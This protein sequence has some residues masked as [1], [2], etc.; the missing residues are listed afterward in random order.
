MK[1]EQGAMITHLLKQRDAA[2]DELTQLA[3]KSAPVDV[4]EE[5]AV[6][7]HLKQEQQNVNE[8]I[9]NTV[10]ASLAMPAKKVSAPR[11]PASVNELYSMIA[12]AEQNAAGKS[13]V[14][15][16]RIDPNTGE[17]IVG[18]Y[19]AYREDAMSP[20]TQNRNAAIV[21]NNPNDIYIGGR[22]P[23]GSRVNAT[24]TGEDDTFYLQKKFEPVKP[25]P[26]T[27]PNGRTMEVDTANMDKAAWLYYSMMEPENPIDF[28]GYYK[29]PT[30]PKHE[31]FV[32][33]FARGATN[34]I[35]NILLSTAGF[36]AQSEYDLG[37]LF[38]NL[39][40]AKETAAYH[41][42]A[43]KLARKT[44]DELISKY[45]WQYGP[46]G[47][48]DAYGNKAGYIFGQAGPM[49]GLSFVSMPTSLSVMSVAEA[50]D[51]ARQ[52]RNAFMDKGVSTGWALGA[53]AG[54]GAG[55]FALG[56]IPEWLGGMYMGAQKAAK[57][58]V[59]MS[60]EAPQE[61]RQ[62][63][64]NRNYIT[65]LSE[66][67]LSEPEQDIFTSVVAGE[68]VDWEAALY[69]MLSAF[70]VSNATLAVS[71]P[72]PAK[73]IQQN[74]AKFKQFLNDHEEFLGMVVKGSG[75][76]IT[77]ANLDEALDLLGD[78]E[79]AGDLWNYL[80]E[81]IVANFDKLTDEQ[82]K[83]LLEKVKQLDP[84][85]NLST[86]FQKLDERIDQMLDDSANIDVAEGRTTLTEDQRTLVKLLLRGVAAQQLA[87]YNVLPSQMT[88][89]QNV[90]G[91]YSDA[92]VSSVAEGSTNVE[93]GQITVN[94]AIQESAT[95]VGTVTA[96]PVEGSLN[97]QA[98]ANIKNEFAS[99]G[100]SSAQ[101]GGFAGL[102]HEF[103]HW[104]E[105][106]TGLPNVGEFMAGIQQLAE[107][108]VP[109]ITAGKEGA[110]LSEAYAY[111]IGYAGDKVKSAL[112]LS[113]PAA[114]Y[115]DFMNLA[116]NAED[117]AQG[118]AAAL[119]GYMESYRNVLKT[120]KQLVDDVIDAYGAPQLRGAIDNFIKTG[121]PGA[122]KLEDMRALNAAL[123]SA[124]DTETASNLG[125]IFE[126]DERANS[127]MRRY[128]EE[129][130]KLL[131]KDRE[132]AA[133]KAEEYRR[134]AN[135]MVGVGKEITPST[136]REDTFEQKANEIV[137]EEETEAQKIDKAIY[138][139]DM[140]GYEISYTDSSAYKSN[141]AKKRELMKQKRKIEGYTD[142]QID[143]ADKLQEQIDEKEAAYRE[144]IMSVG[145]E[146]NY[147]V[148]TET[149]KKNQK[150]REKNQDALRKQHEEERVTLQKEL[151]NILSRA[152]SR[153]HTEDS[154]AEA[155]ANEET[156]PE[157]KPA[158]EGKK[159]EIKS[160][161]HTEGPRAGTPY[162]VDELVKGNYDEEP[163]VVVGYLENAAQ[164]AKNENIGKETLAGKTV[165]LSSING[166][167]QV[168]LEPSLGN[169][170]ADHRAAYVILAKNK[171]KQMN[172]KGLLTE[173]HKR[174][175]KNTEMFAVRSKLKDQST[176]VLNFLATKVATKV[177]TPD[178]IS[179]YTAM[180]EFDKA[181]SDL[182]VDFGP[183]TPVETAIAAKTAAE[184]FAYQLQDLS[185]SKDSSVRRIIRGGPSLGGEEYLRGMLPEQVDERLSFGVFPSYEGGYFH[186]EM[187]EPNRSM[188]DAVADYIYSLDKFIEDKTFEEEKQVFGKDDKQ[189]SQNERKAI[190]TL[191]EGVVYQD[192]KQLLFPFARNE[193]RVTASQKRAARAYLGT[194][195]SADPMNKFFGVAYDTP[196][197]S[198]KFIDTSV[199]STARRVISRPGATDAEIAGAQNILNAGAVM[200]SYT[201]PI[202]G[203][204]KRDIINTPTPLEELGISMEEA[205]EQIRAAG[206]EPYDFLNG[207]LADEAREKLSPDYIRKN[208]ND[209]DPDVY[210]KTRRSMLARLLKDIP[211]IGESKNRAERLRILH[212][213]SSAKAAVDQLFQDV[214]DSE[215]SYN[216]NPTGPKEAGSLLSAEDFK[217]SDRFQEKLA[218]HQA[219][220]YTEAVDA[221]NLDVS[222][223]IAFPYGNNIFRGVI[224][225][226]GKM[227]SGATSYIILEDVD[228]GVWR[229]KDIPSMK[230]PPHQLR[231]SE[232]DLRN[233]GFLRKPVEVA[234]FNKYADLLN[235]FDDI[236]A[237]HENWSNWTRIAQ[238]SVAEAQEDME[239]RSGRKDITE[240]E[241]D[242]SAD[243]D[244]DNPENEYYAVRSNAPDV[245]EVDPGAYVLMD[246]NMTD[247][248]WS[249]LLGGTEEEL[250]RR[251]E[252]LQGGEN[253]KLALWEM[254]QAKV[255][256][257]K[258]KFASYGGALRE[259]LK[260]M[261]DGIAN[262][263]WNKWTKV[264]LLGGWQTG[265]D[266]KLRMI[267][268]DK[269]GKSFN[270]VVASS[271]AQEISEGMRHAFD[272]AVTDNVFNGSRIEYERWVNKLPT[273][274]YDA[275]LSNGT[276]QKVTKDEIISMGIAKRA[277]EKNL[278]DTYNY[279]NP[280]DR[281]RGFYKNFDE[282]LSHMT[283]QDWNFV[284]TAL[285]A[286]ASARGQ[287]GVLPAYWAPSTLAKDYGRNGWGARLTSAPDNSINVVNSMEP[288]AATGAYQSVLSII[289]STALKQSGLPKQLKSLRDILVFEDIDMSY[290]KQLSPDE[291]A[292]YNDIKSQAAQLKSDI[293]AA[294]G[295]TMFKW[296]IDNIDVDLKF[297]PLV[298]D[299][300]KNP[301]MG[302]FQKATRN[303]ASSLLMLNLKQ[304][305]V[306]LGN[307]DLFLGLSNSGMLRFYTSD[308]VN[309]WMHIRDAWKLAMEIP[310]FKRR[311]EQSGLSEQMRRV[312]D[313]N[314]ESFF[315]DIQQALYRSGKG[316]AGDIVGA[317]NTL[318][319]IS[320]KY[321]LATNVV[322]DL[323]GIAL[324]TYAVWNDVLARNNGNVQAAQDEIVDHVLNRVS[325][326]NYMTR[327]AA[328]KL[329]HRAGLEALVAFKNDQLQ[330][331]G[332]ICEAALRL[333]NSSDPEV[334]AKAWKD[335]EAAAWS[336]LRYIAVQA[337]WIVAM[338]QLL[339]GHDLDDEEKKYLYEATVRETLSQIGDTTQVGSFIVPIFTGIY[340]GRDMGSTLLP[341]GGIQRATVAAR[342]GNV[343]KAL[344][345]GGAF[346]GA[347]PVAPATVRLLDA[348][349]R[350]SVGDEKEQ[351]VGRLM[352]LGRS[353]PTAQ[354]MMGYS[355]SQKTGK[356]RNKK[357]KKESD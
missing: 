143:K 164:W 128:A 240:I 336:T 347:T 50:A 137:A 169:T 219:M 184:D 267:F 299:M 301:V 73:A 247:E 104:I 158:E 146:D 65:A 354:K 182:Y 112:G 259:T 48:G 130:D 135:E 141:R 42:A 133:A 68:D 229:A 19:G 38:A 203:Y 224:S 248:D 80:K 179:L 331:V 81:G 17:Q 311:L 69:T 109:G 93:T 37:E 323:V 234:N 357:S 257:V 252:S 13:V 292:L 198:E 346:I 235:L 84:E 295:P 277:V 103:W 87:Y 284:D 12:P 23:M 8:K 243:Y 280:E 241:S 231:I 129:Y 165:K 70:I 172:E 343:F 117:I 177:A 61:L 272:K 54:T 89:P 178:E 1:K 47:V 52:V 176:N 233:V 78:P 77:Q 126:T 278:I 282:L 214:I 317:I 121:N 49:V 148:D 262:R 271:R 274:T 149:F 338:A 155:P 207:K 24:Y 327:S 269:V 20:S 43:S 136:S 151:D 150:E 26:L 71:S 245:P 309:A 216:Y 174:R 314:E 310:E 64:R 225:F 230:V 127:F 320:A 254:R 303:V 83:Q 123:A 75:G 44:T 197:I 250:I 55:V 91:G 298:K 185:K 281:M 208:L 86:E 31:G 279:T 114:D 260:N 106:M 316:R 131:A 333:I 14:M 60:R 202:R 51:S 119:K 110:D 144:K 276:T 6:I 107:S 308:R 263:K 100:V 171:L 154:R 211:S 195:G 66:A 212:A 90:F 318:G 167:L 349:Y 157:E 134:V 341:I 3:S 335:I 238:A 285:E 204:L 302:A 45:T 332:S 350:V 344:A 232:A 289:G 138:G 113:G 334:R 325:S 124:V 261:R 94:N 329:M 111:A 102:S 353:E 21:T 139:L 321:G 253:A 18:N 227:P 63:F 273:E 251:L 255:E 306:N 328:T 160:R 4:P 300:T 46:E 324:G 348:L 188:I 76:A 287:D 326:S 210:M 99:A 85:S 319:K 162:D 296:L 57:N 25:Y 98:S 192:T 115:V 291:E 15:N 244:E 345:E 213:I 337:G 58:F 79:H 142:E 275:Q 36:V 173:E 97:Q 268:G 199:L 166:E 11:Q 315:K 72:D 246:S 220:G 305:Y 30:A 22:V 140:S 312:A 322:P 340:E 183:Y 108:L 181:L 190:K 304:G 191:K 290:F 170:R 215:D 145:P 265:L 156:K 53:A 342:K 67:L 194:V 356:L 209:P 125:D 105:T 286:L 9:K 242:E 132:G 256:Q 330:K 294:I 297:N 29:M 27:Y 152:E 28:F 118:T 35:P 221:S 196:D 355:R 147:N 266:R 40:G 175:A 200:S 187:K 237:A 223:E 205:E 264:L 95:P 270:F 88:I 5:G 307:Y 186:Y 352:I 153:M 2:V 351:A 189:M 62:I 82:K 239:L 180:A 116:L 7:S 59:K 339:T 122:L 34:F 10:S 222:D 39:F 96:A 161:M 226:K 56:M 92:A 313:M 16:P 193:L 258:P 41:N 101:S 74:V 120:N 206:L 201:N 236:C 168:K 33:G 293:E 159:P 163:D 217:Q 218:E 32:H 283:E 288:L 249:A 228:L